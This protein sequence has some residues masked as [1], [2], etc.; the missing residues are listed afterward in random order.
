[1]EVSTSIQANKLD[2]ILKTKK[3]PASQIIVYQKLPTLCSSGII[4]VT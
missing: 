4:T 3:M 2:V 1:M